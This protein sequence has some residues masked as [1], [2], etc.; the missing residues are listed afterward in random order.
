MRMGQEIGTA[1]DRRR[2]QNLSPLITRFRLQEKSMIPDPKLSKVL[3][4]AS[5][6][7]AGGQ[8]KAGCSPGPEVIPALAY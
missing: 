8:A 3:A 1:A 6:R 2:A 7:S 4:D 5:A